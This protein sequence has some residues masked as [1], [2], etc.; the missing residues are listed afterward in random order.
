MVPSEGT[1]ASGGGNVSELGEEGHKGATKVAVGLNGEGDTGV[2]G[3]AVALV[4]GPAVYV[5]LSGRSL[6]L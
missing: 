2:A 1:L 4:L 6:L 5:S 3:V